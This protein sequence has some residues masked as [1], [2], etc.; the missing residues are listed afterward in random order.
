MRQG[1]ATSECGSAQR[2]TLTVKHWTKDSM[3]RPAS[4]A[5]RRRSFPVKTDLPVSL[6]VM[7]TWKSRCL[8]SQYCGR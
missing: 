2:S 8:T 4:M 5:M 6:L 7:G 1:A 3:S